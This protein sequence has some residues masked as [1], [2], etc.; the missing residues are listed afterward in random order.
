MFRPDSRREV[1]GSEGRP[2]PYSGSDLSAGRSCPSSPGRCAD[3]CT[4]A[5]HRAGAP[6]SRP[7]ARRAQ[8]GPVLGVSGAH[9]AYSPRNGNKGQGTELPR[10]LH[11]PLS[12][13]AQA[14]LGRASRH[15]R[16]QRS[17]LRTAYPWGNHGKI[18][19][20]LSPNI[21]LP[22]QKVP[23]SVFEWPP[24]ARNFV[25]SVDPAATEPGILSWQMRELRLTEGE[26]PTGGPSA[27]R[28]GLRRGPGRVCT[29]S[30]CSVSPGQLG[31]VKSK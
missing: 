14:C 5:S 30:P 11:W 1:C 13:T 16:S 2:V 20:I 29:L 8:Q 24:P 15:R 23:A 12:L 17:G 18:H 19:G 22:N 25:R 26:G 7:G 9:Q 3:A 6:K 27:V 4:G 21:H 28:A 31:L 10:A